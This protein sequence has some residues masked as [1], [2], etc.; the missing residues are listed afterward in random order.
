MHGLVTVFGGTGFIGAQVVRALARKGVRIRVAV[1]NPGRGYRLRMLGDV[2]Q[3]QI[4]QANIRD[5]ASVA[6]ALDGAEAAV[7]L[8]GVLHSAGRQSFGAVHVEGARIV[9]QAARAAK[10]TH[11]VQMS[12]LGAD[13][14]SASAYARSKAAGEAAVRDCIKS[15]VIIRPSIVFG[16]EDHFF[17]RFGAMAAVSPVLP[18]IG[19]GETRFQPVYVGDVAQAI[20]AALIDPA[21][22]GRAFELGGP[23]VHTFRDLM[24][25]VC[26]V[27]L[28]K[29]ILMPIPFGPASLIGLAGD[30]LAWVRS[31]VGLVPP[32]PITRDQ[33]EQLK[34]DNV[35]ADGAGGL[36]ALGVSPTALEP[37]LPTYMYR[38]RRGGQFAEQPAEA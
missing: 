4:V 30:I 33:V 14:S 28:R 10:I 12:A 17:N 8:V 19:G 32:P 27:T 36:A 31:G 18:L 26:E 2:G 35:V 25:L 9:A 11:F 24:S 13:E 23:G 20:A 29:R 37:I 34:V 5:A 15:A 7:N 3:I 22:A 16:P 38:Y 6:R 1:R 21:F